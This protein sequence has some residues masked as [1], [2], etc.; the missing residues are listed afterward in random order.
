MNGQKIFCPF[1]IGDD[2]ILNEVKDPS[3]R[4]KTCNKIAWDIVPS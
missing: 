3:S 1:L 4:L 2:V